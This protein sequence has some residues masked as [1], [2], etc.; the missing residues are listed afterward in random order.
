MCWTRELAPSDGFFYFAIS[1]PLFRVMITHGYL[2]VIKQAI[3]HP[4][5]WEQ[6]IGQHFLW[7]WSIFL[8]IWIGII[9][10]PTII[11]YESLCLFRICK[12]SEIFSWVKSFESSELVRYWVHKP[13]DKSQRF[14]HPVFTHRPR[15][16]Y[17]RYMRNFVYIPQIKRFR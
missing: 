10:R 1:F 16:K 17:P 4:R 6:S 5:M 2:L 15:D 13:H 12:C 7:K 8:W 14:M 11:Q 3:I 9:Y